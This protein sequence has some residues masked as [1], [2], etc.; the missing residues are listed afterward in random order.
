VAF[1]IT[2]TTY[3][4]WLP[5]DERG[6]VSNVVKNDGGFDPKQNVYESAC[7]DGD[8]Y[9]RERA[10]KLMKDAPVWLDAKQAY[11]VAESLV[12][13]VTNRGWH[14]VRAAIMRNHVHVL[15]TNCPE[16]GPGVR[17]ILKGVSQAKL[18]DVAGANRRW[19]TQGGSDRQKFDD[20]AMDAADEYIEKQ[21]G[22][23]AEIVDN[24]A[25]RV[26]ARRG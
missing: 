8:S 26:E 14:I 23:L 21:V 2:W 1:H 20:A 5:G 7:G 11:V 3:G 25:I 12:E 18:S 6:H 17:R 10:Q 16:D 4:T 24:V 15:V 22:Q 19:W 13:T 9:L